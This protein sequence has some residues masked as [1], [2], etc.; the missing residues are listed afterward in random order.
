MSRNFLTNSERVKS[1]GR[2]AK[3]GVVPWN[4]GIIAPMPRCQDCNKLLKDRR[5]I[6]CKSCAVSVWRS[7]RPLSL[8]HRKSVAKSSI[9]QVGKNNPNWKGG[10]TPETIRLR[11]SPEA[12][13]WRR[14]VLKKDDYTCQDCGVVEV[15]MTAHHISSW[16]KYPQLR[17]DVENGITLCADCHCKI[18]PLLANSPSIKLVSVKE[19]VYHSI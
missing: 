15:Q 1:L 12:R 4:K 6:R 16:A 14:D 18:D 7:G 2:Y 5:S 3:K 10:I 9:F 11:A 13:R 19:D 17:F 8:E